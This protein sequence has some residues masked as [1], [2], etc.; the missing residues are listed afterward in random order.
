[1]ESDNMMRENN[2]SLRKLFSETRADEDLVELTAGCHTVDELK[3]ILGTLDFFVPDIKISRKADLS[4]LVARLYS[5]KE[6]FEALMEGLGD[7]ARELIRT[8]AWDGMQSGRDVSRIFGIPAFAPGAG[9]SYNADY[10][11]GD[12]ELPAPFYLKQS[13]GETVYIR[14]ELQELFCSL[15]APPVMGDINREEHP[16]ED[17]FNYEEG[18]DFYKSL[19][20]LINQL[21]DLGFFKRSYTD[22][23]QKT[24]L[25]K[26]AATQEISS[27]AFDALGDDPY[28]RLRMILQFISF[29]LTGEEESLPRPP[30]ESLDSLGFLKDGVAGFFR[31]GR[32]EFDLQVLL[33]HIR[34]KSKASY[35][36]RSRAFRRHH[37]PHFEVLFSKWPFEGWVDPE[38]CLKT[39][40]R[41]STARPLMPDR[42]MYFMIET[43]SDWGHSYKERTSI[44]NELDY[45]RNVYQPYFR[46]L[47]TLWAALGLFELAWD[48]E[49]AAGKSHFTAVR[50]TNLGR[51]VFGLKETFETRLKAPV[52]KVR[53]DSRFT[54]AHVDPSYRTAVSFFRGIG[55]PVGEN[56]FLV[57]GESLAKNCPTRADLEERFA[58]LERYC[59]EEFPPVWLD[60]KTR[61]MKRYVKLRIEPDWV[62]YVLTEEDEILTDYLNS[63]D[64][65]LFSRMEGRRIAVRK[66]D[67]RKFQN[68]LKKG[69]F[70]PLTVT[71]D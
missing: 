71:V 18:E 22:K 45:K 57:S 21:R 49:E 9:A 24:I 7:T 27:F 10:S 37:N 38:A 60:L 55:T 32:T 1:M 33:P 47:F 35:I 54:A 16:G 62:V 44:Y 64:S 3:K 43:F 67:I 29:H 30:E 17:F 56:L 25:K 51:Y 48:D 58:A 5:E 28:R 68:L 52:E 6:L 50:M 59:K 23:V 14:H 70:T 69:G 36:E 12:L 53:L 46:S 8:C 42:D 41:M 39:F 20:S 63:L 26:I 11:R 65:P 13:Y 31:S 4:P 15:M 40:Y 34:T 61:M 19:N 66:E 2:E